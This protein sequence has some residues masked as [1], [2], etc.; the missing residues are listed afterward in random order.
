MIPAGLFISTPLDE[1]VQTHG[2]NRLSGIAPADLPEELVVPR[3]RVADVSKNRELDAAGERDIRGK[4][5]GPVLVSLNQSRITHLLKTK[6]KFC[7][8]QPCR[9]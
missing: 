8:V 5:N 6:Q 2:F 1:E 4:P 9:A 7:T 3:V